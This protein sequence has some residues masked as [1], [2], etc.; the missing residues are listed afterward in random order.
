M[1]NKQSITRKIVPVKPGSEL[2]GQVISLGRVNAKTLGYF[3]DDT[4]KDEV[5]TDLFSAIYREG[6]P[7]DA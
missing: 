6:F 5:P 1:P 4:F 3:P 2:L 7:D